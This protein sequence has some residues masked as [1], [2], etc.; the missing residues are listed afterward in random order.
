MEDTRLTKGSVE[1]QLTLFESQEGAKLE[2]QQGLVGCRW[3][4]NTQKED[5]Q[6]PEGPTVIVDELLDASV[7]VMIVMDETSTR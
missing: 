2:G 5:L 6:S 1:S 4:E 7:V 3:D